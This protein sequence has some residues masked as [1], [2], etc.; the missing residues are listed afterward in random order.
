MTEQRGFANPP[1]HFL[2]RHWIL[3][4][5]GLSD[6][7]PDVQQSDMFRWREQCGLLSATDVGGLNEAVAQQLNAQP[8]RSVG[9]LLHSADT[10]QRVAS[11]QCAPDSASAN[12]VQMVWLDGT[13]K[14]RPILSGH[15]SRPDP[16][17][18]DEWLSASGEIV[19]PEPLGDWPP[20]SFPRWEQAFRAWA[21]ATLAAQALLFDAP[22][23]AEAKAHALALYGIVPVQI[24]GTD[25]G[26]ATPFNTNRLPANEPMVMRAD[27]LLADTGQPG[28]PKALS[29][30][31][32]RSGA[33]LLVVP[34][35]RRLEGRLSV[36]QIKL[37][38]L[39]WRVGTLGRPTQVE[40]HAGFDLPLLLRTGP[41]QTLSWTLYAEQYSDLGAM[42]EQWK[43][44]AQVE[45]RVAAH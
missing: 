13:S 19:V 43:G 25:P 45:V 9:V 18:A 21:E 2:P 22:T 27:G 34:E 7:P 29:I 3:C 36:V 23:G 44:D 26:I 17:A 40:L 8:R 24:R 39:D 33:Y 41:D 6:L 42:L 10:G 11:L 31:V 38:L 14:D 35:R 5:L 16:E 37:T 15:L 32:G 28:V 20:A 12:R 30:R 4:G 1:S